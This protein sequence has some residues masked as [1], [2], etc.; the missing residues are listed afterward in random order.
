[1]KR[2]GEAYENYQSIQGCTWRRNYNRHWRESKPD[3][4]LSKENWVIDNE[5]LWTTSD[6][7][8]LYDTLT[9][10]V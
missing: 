6:H 10:E 5:V 4:I 8:I 2:M 3:I 1:M 7:K 9:T